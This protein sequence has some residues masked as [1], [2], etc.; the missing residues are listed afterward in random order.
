[1]SPDAIIPVLLIVGFIVSLAMAT[2]ARQKVPGDQEYRRP[3]ATSG[4][5]FDDA[6]YGRRWGDA[7][8]HA[9]YGRGDGLGRGAGHTQART[10]RFDRDDALG[11]GYGSGRDDIR[12]ERPRYHANGSSTYGTR[13][14]YEDGPDDGF[15]AWARANG[16]RW[17]DASS[18]P[19]PPPPSPSVPHWSEVLDIS[20]TA[21]VKE[22]RA[23][24]AKKMRTLHPDVAGTDALTSQRC[25]DARLAYDQGRQ[26]AQNAGRP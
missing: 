25:A 20:K 4:S 12:R 23:A 11:R 1:M 2:M 21:G 14:S 15:D 19:P 18:A 6:P 10:S 16:F 24:Y 9:D 17:H 8:M 3:Q 22:I 5:F 7:G 26:D 13:S